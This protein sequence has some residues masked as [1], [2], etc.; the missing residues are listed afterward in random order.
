MAKA[1]I[2][3]IGVGWWAVEVYVPAVQNSPDAELVA[4]SRRDH[5]ALR[6]ICARFGIPAGHADYREMLARE[7]LDGVI[8]ASPHTAHF[9]HAMAALDRGAH[10]VD[11][12]MTTD[13]VQAR[14]WAPR[15][16]GRARDRHSIWLELQGFRAPRGGTGPWRRDRAGG[17][18]RL[19]DGLGAGGSDGGSA[20][21]RDHRAHV[22]PARLDL[23]RS[24]ERGR[25]WVGPVVARA[26]S[27]VPDYRS[28]ALRSLCDLRPLAHRRRFP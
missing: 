4:V 13:A 28:T 5:D 7:S 19:P 18:C 12:P 14:A 27:A 26:G 1:R 24:G 10:V 17:A 6:R 21:G 22:P 20:D 23:G 25:L 11:K 15:R 2:G 9:E 8:V 3:I 16:P